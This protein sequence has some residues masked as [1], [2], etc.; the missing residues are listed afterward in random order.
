MITPNAR[1]LVAALSLTVLAAGSPGLPAAHAQ[2][3]DQTGEKGWRAVAPGRVEPLSGTIR[4]AVPVAGVI[5]EVLIKANDTV[6]AGEPLIRL[7]DRE[8]RARLAS[9]EA[10]A[11]MRKRVRNK[12]SMPSG[13]A[14]RRR[15]EDAVADAETAVFQT[16]SFVDKAAAER[17]AGRGSDADVEA[18]RSG[19]AR[20]RDR[21]KQEAAGLRATE[22]DAPLPT[23][24]EGQVNMARSDLALARETLDKM[25]IRAPIGG[26][27]LQVNAKPGE[28]AAPA[29]TP[30]L[31]LLGDISAL[32]VRAEVDERDIEKI[33][34]GQPVL[35][36]AAAF[37]GRQTAGSVSF[38]A[39]LVEA[40]RNNAPGQRNM[41]DVDVVE[42]LVNLAEPGPLAVGMKVDV[43]FRQ[44]ESPR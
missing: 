5:G 28:L 32:R 31:V 8:A 37:P 13:A 14:A 40:G 12:E 4:V 22:I 2:A 34:V 27:I 39:P 21:L 19:L 30:P 17:R 20:A 16:Q 33:K 18:A 38:V 23:V 7:D 3:N 44:D 11:A 35:V 36:R 26:T 15:A 42:V 43:Y 9:A 10:Q 25:T 29:A 1:T 41:T 24:A 6:F